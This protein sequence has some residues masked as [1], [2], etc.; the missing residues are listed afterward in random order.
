MKIKFQ[1]NLIKII[2]KII[3]T[4]VSLLF[5]QSN[6]KP[7]PDGIRKEKSLRDFLA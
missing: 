4:K 1:S 6:S 2:F 3:L 7:D 5:T